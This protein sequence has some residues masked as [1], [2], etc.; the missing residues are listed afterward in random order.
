MSIF[1]CGKKILGRF[2]ACDKVMD[3][4]D[5]NVVLILTCSINMFRWFLTWTQDIDNDDHFVGLILI[6]GI[7]KI[8]LLSSCVQ[9]LFAVLTCSCGFRYDPNIDLW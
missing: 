5:Q 3:N 7:K 8:R 6:C 9:Y 4:A 2:Q 1:I